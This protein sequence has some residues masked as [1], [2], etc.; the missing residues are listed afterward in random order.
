RRAPRRRPNPVSTLAAILV[1]GGLLAL[2]GWVIFGGHAGFIGIGSGPTTE[3]SSTSQ[4]VTSGPATT[5]YQQLIA[6]VP[7]SFASSCTPISVP[8]A[9]ASQGVDAEV[10]CQPAALGSSGILTYAHYR[11]Q[12]AMQHTYDAL[13]QGV[14]SGD[15]TSES[16]QDSYSLQSSS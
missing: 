8:A 15:C 6:R 9:D 11:T 4:T 16:G 5:A 1:T 2:S 13:A 10:A 12:G 3:P 7:T 14:P